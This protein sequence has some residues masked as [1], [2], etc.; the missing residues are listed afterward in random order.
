MVAKFGLVQQGHIPVV[1]EMLDR[2][3]SWQ[4]INRAIGWA[5][6]SAEKF[7]MRYLRQ[8]AKAYEEALNE[9]SALPSDR[10]DEACCIA[11]NAIDTFN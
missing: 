7:Y 4:E 9:I 5:G 2:H 10:Q 8:K 3:C 11:M 1:E 6:D